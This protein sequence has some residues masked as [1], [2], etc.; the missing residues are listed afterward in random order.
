MKRYLSMYLS[1][2]GLPK[3]EV[4]ILGDLGK[5]AAAEFQFKW[6]VPC[7]LESSLQVS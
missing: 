5:L 1:E 4:Q 6:Y 2:S 3:K 7:I